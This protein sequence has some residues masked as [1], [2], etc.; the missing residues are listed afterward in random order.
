MVERLPGG[1]AVV[2][3]RLRGKDGQPAR[4]EAMSGALQRATHRRDDVSVA[5][6]AQPDGSWRA[7]ARPPDGSGNWDLAVEARGGGGQA[8]ASL[9]L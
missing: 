2:E 9:R 4:A 3:A 6:M 5:F 8:S 7:T 1:G